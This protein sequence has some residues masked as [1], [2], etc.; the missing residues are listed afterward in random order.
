[1]RGKLARR[2]KKPPEADPALASVSNTPH[3]QSVFTGDLGQFGLV[4]IAQ[5]M[6][7]GRKTGLL[8]VRS[9]N[10]VGYIYFRDG[11]VVYVMDDQFLQGLQAALQVFLWREGTFEFDFDK[12]TPGENITVTT[13]NLLFE[14]A[15]Q[16]DE[17][18]QGLRGKRR[19]GGTVARNL[20]ERHM[21]AI[22]ETFA[23]IAKRVMPE[24]KGGGRIAP[25]GSS[26][27]TWLKRLTPTT[28]DSLFLIPGLKPKLKKGG[29]VTNLDGPRVD[30]NS[31]DRF[32]RATL[33]RPQQEALRKDRQIEILVEVGQA[34]PARLQISGEGAKKMVVAHLLYKV[35]DLFA[36]FETDPSFV[37]LVS[38]LEQGLVLVAGAPSSGKSRLMSSL[39]RRRAEGRGSLVL[40]LSRTREFIFENTTGLVLQRQQPKGTVEFGETI[41]VCLGQNPDLLAVDGLDGPGWIETVVRASSTGVGIIASLEAD[42]PQEAL[43]QASDFLERKKDV[44]SRKLFKENFR[45]LLFLEKHEPSAQ[46]LTGIRVH[47]YGPSETPGQARIEVPALG[48]MFGVSQVTD[49]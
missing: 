2:K 22:R 41:R 49:L 38:G 29:V 6:M 25:R 34:A 19:K 35:P 13:E 14:V 10:R 1:M 45:S 47:H 23:E 28:G 37:D 12:P 39:I 5:T 40:L 24:V 26:V 43:H 30:P 4:D 36:P 8:T 46:G 31:I 42:T 7:M 11:Q 21:E 20:Q 18:E 44:V 48:T 16:L 15:R 27:E 33:D 3:G 9:G 32:V 17:A